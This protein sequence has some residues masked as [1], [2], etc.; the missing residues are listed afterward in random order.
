MW[1]VNQTGTVAVN[2]DRVDYFSRIIPGE[3]DARIGNDR[4]CLGSY[5]DPTDAFRA[6]RIA[7][8][9]DIKIYKME[10]D[11]HESR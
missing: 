4:I 6:L 10:G 9:R 7:L 5:A 1:I 8:G 11:T 2:S 3:V